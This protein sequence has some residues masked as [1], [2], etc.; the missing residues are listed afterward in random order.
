M[1]ASFFLYPFEAGDIVT[2]RKPHP[3]GGNTWSLVRVAGDVTLRCQTC[4]RRMVLK[5]SAL[6]KSC[7]SIE[8]N[9]EKDK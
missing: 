7:K 8:K 6:E 5:R 2:L 4:G 3:C 9:D 1:N